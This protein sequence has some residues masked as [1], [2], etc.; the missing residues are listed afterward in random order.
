MLAFADRFRGRSNVD[1]RWLAIGVTD[2]EK[3]MMGIG[4]A[5]TK[6]PLEEL[7]KLNDR[8]ED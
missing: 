1:Q 3:G 6:A 7:K 2:V 4:H 8:L 5:V